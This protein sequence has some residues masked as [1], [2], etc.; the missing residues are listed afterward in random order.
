VLLSFARR[1]YHPLTDELA[2]L[3]DEL[4]ERA[5]PLP[6]GIY[7]QREDTSFGPLAARI[8][9]AIVEPVSPVEVN[10]QEGAALILGRLGSHMKSAHS[11]DVAAAA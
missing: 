11:A 6:V 1:E 8:R 2:A 3:A 9:A 5:Q 10:A 7:R 4:D